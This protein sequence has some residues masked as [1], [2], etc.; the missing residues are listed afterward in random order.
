M[1]AFFPLPFITVWACLTRSCCA[2]TA[3]TP[4]NSVPTT[5]TVRSIGQFSV[6]QTFQVKAA[7]SQIEL[8]PLWTTPRAAFHSAPRC[9][10]S[11]AMPPLM[12]ADRDPDPFGG[13]RHIDVI[14]FVFA[15]QPLD[16]R[17]DDRRTGADRAGLARALDAERI[18]LARHVMGLEHE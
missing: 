2:T 12:F 6:S 8:R 17:V 16:N 4:S 5:T 7:D 14:D 18:G 1:P 10:I 15:P 9:Q 3:P 11:E 13:R